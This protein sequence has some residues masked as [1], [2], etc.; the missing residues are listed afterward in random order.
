MHSRMTCLNYYNDVKIQCLILAI[1]QTNSTLLQSLKARIKCATRK[2]TANSC[3][4]TLAPDGIPNK[5]FP[6]PQPTMML[7][8]ALQL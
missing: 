1:C 7:N 2:E 5:M 3:Q 6:T 4:N 8:F